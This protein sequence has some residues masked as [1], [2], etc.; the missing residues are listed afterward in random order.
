MLEPYI[1]RSLPPPVLLSASLFLSTLG[2][3]LCDFLATCAGFYIHQSASRGESESV[4]AV[5]DLL[6]SNG[7]CRERERD[8]ERETEKREERE[9][10]RERK[11]AESRSSGVAKRERGKGRESKGV[12]SEAWR[13]AVRQPVES[14]GRV[15]LP[16]SQRV[17]LT[18][19]ESGYFCGQLF[20]SADHSVRSPRLT[21][22]S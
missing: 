19:Y 1:S 2:S 15:Q 17:R 7:G 13:G 5:I 10:E 11:G 16:S 9:R 8:I 4:V 3:V 18:P 20:L 22:L 14:A 6:R 21:A 12:S